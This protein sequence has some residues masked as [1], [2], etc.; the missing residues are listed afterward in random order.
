MALLVSLFCVRDLC[1]EVIQAQVQMK[2]KLLQF[3]YLGWQVC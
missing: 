1:F 3:I 2:D